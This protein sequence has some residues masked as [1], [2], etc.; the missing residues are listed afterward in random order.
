MPTIP[1]VAANIFPWLR[2]CR[3]WILRNANFITLLVAWWIFHIEAQISDGENCKSQA[4]FEWQE[5][6]SMHPKF[7]FLWGDNHLYVIGFLHGK[8]IWRLR[9]RQAR[10]LLIIQTIFLSHETSQPIIGFNIKLKEDESRVKVW[11]ICHRIWIE[12]IWK[13]S[14]FIEWTF[15]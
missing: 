10:K 4:P 12:F 15:F 14:N 13:F 1:E 8:L 2:P 3:Y 9:K 7:Y 6:S 11:Y 5:F